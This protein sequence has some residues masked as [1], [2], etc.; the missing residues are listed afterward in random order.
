MVAMLQQ[1][2]LLV[3]DG[4]SLAVILQIFEYPLQTGWVVPLL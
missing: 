2:L 4:L 1:R 3:D